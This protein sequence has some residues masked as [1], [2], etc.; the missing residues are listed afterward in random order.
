MPKKCCTHFDGEPCTSN[1]DSNPEKVHVFRF[2]RNKEESIIWINSLP[3]KVKVNDDTV[4]CEKHWPADFPRKS[5][6]GPLG[7]RPTNPCTYQSNSFNTD[8]KCIFIF[9]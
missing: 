5:C 6:Q 3:S 2:P 9:I 8:K 1:Y 7:Y 4:L